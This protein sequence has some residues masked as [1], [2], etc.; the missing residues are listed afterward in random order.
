MLISASTALVSISVAAVSSPIMA[1][2]AD[3]RP[4]RRPSRRIIAPAVVLGSLVLAAGIGLS[5]AAVA[6]APTAPPGSPALA[7]STPSPPG[8]LVA[9]PSPAPSAPAETVP[10]RAATHAIEV[11]ARLQIALDAARKRLGIPGVSVTV[12]FPDGTSW[13]GSSG[14]ADVQGRISVDSGTAFA[15]GS[16]S[17]TY[18]AAL[19]LALVGEGRIALDMPARSYLPESGLDWRITVR[20]LLNHTSGLDDFFIHASTD[21]ALL[22]ETSA[23]W[24]PARSLGYVGKRYFVPGHGW[25]YSNTN[26]LYLGLIAERVA[27]KPLAQQ[28]RERFL[29][30]QDLDDTW[31]QAAEKPRSQTA[32]GYRFANPKR[33]AKPIDLSDGTP[34]VPFTSVVTAAAGAGSIAAT[35]SDVA[36][37]ARALYTGQ[38]LGPAMTDEMFNAIAGTAAY[39]PR[40]GYGFGVQAF[41]IVGHATLGHSGRLL[42]F[43]AAVRYLPADSLTIAVLTNQSRAD[44]G[45]IVV[46]LLGIVFAPPPSCSRCS[47]PS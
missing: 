8:S 35:S 47:Q 23:T 30:P 1:P 22:A 12:I 45:L 25:H 21:R 41:P 28:L 19:I 9:S 7:A 14:L 3:L 2:P 36:R 24:T 18:T 10:T 46:D 34:V 32:H 40:V 5:G 42:G 6:T 4:G 31:Y 13:L 17:K 26:Y 20:E 39:A 38:V 15:V 37:W 16:I 43:R 29:G 33:A 11:R 27:G 44:P